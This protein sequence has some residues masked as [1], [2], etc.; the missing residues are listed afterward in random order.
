MGAAA[1]GEAAGGIAMID[2]D[3]VVAIGLAFPGVDLGTSYGH[4]ALKLRGKMLAA[5]DK[6]DDHFV[7]SATR[8]EIEMLKN[9]EPACFFQTPHYEGWPAVLVRYAEAD[10]ERIAVLIARAW[11]R[12][13]SK[14]QRAARG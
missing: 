2:W 5:G 3:A 12:G 14:A 13:A 9:T 10:P 11:Q 1:R 8:D 7:L 4:P 6:A